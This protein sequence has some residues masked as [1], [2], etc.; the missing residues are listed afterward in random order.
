MTE[1]MFEQYL[2]LLRYY[3]L[4]GSEL[5]LLWDCYSARKTQGVKDTATR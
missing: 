5:H 1:E 2:E 3:Y 4:D